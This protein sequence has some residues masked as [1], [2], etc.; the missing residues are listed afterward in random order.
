M[1]EVKSIKISHDTGKMPRIRTEIGLDELSPNEQLKENVKKLK[2]NAKKESTYFSSS[3][4]PIS[5]ETV[6][7][8]D[9]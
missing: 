6:Y 8:W 7:E 2:E 1:K 4:I 5:E 9:K 3:A